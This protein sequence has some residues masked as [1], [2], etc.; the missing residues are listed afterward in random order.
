MP[1]SRVRLMLVALLGVFAF[2]AVAAAAAQALP[3]SPFWS[4]EGVRLG[5]GETHYI[6]A[7][8]HTSFIL[9]AGTITITCTVLQL[10]EGVLLG[11]AAGHYGTNDEVAEFSSCK[12]TGNGTEP[13]CTVVEPI[14]TKSLKSEL[15]TN[16]E[17]EKRLVLLTP[18]NAALEFATLAFKEKEAGKELCPIKST[19]VTGELAGEVEEDSENLGESYLLNFPET[20]ITEVLLIEN[21]TSTIHKVEKLLAFGAEAREIGTALLL[22]ANTKRETELAK[23]SP[24]I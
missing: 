5:A 21:G 22:L 6:T 8:A 13:S 4:R 17:G 15:V 10:K 2:G 1:K 23:W 19:K 14:V 7:R 24:L 20:R 16:R 3:E 9:K 11:S 18:S 12:Q